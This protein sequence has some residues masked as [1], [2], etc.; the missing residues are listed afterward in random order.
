VLDDA[1]FDTELDDGLKTYALNEHID[2]SEAASTKAGIATRNTCNRKQ[3]QKNVPSMQGNKFQVALAQITTFFGTSDTSMGCANMSVKLINKGIHQCAYNFWN[4]Y[5]EAE[6]SVG[7]EMKI[8]FDNTLCNP[9]N[10][11]L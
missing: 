4:G 5:E 9:Y 3:P 2:E 11:N 7:K 8:S 1:V 6:E 10:G